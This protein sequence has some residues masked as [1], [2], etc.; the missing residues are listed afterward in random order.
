MVMLV[1]VAVPPPGRSAGKWRKSPPLVDNGRSHGRKADSAPVNA[2]VSATPEIGSFDFYTP[3]QI[4]PR[5][6][7]C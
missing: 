3:G 2:E 5:V 4:T 1:Q 6:Q 7:E